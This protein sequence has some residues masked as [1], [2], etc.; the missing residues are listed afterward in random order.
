MA[1][2]FD[3]IPVINFDAP[4]EEVRATI[5][6]LPEKQR[7]EAL[8]AWADAYVAKER[9]EGG[10]GQAINNGVRALAR[11]TP[12]G[13]WLDEANALTSAGINTVSGGYLGAP[14][15]EAKAY[16]NAADRAYDKANPTASTVLQVAGAVGSAPLAPA[17]QV[18]RGGSLGA[19]MINAGITGAGYGAAYGLGEGDTWSEGG[20]NAAKGATLGGVI[21]SAAPAVAR[22]VGNAA[23]YVMNIVKGV[24]QGAQGFERGA[25]NR[26]SRAMTDDGLTT[27]P[28]YEQRMTPLGREGMLLDAGENLQNQAGAIA[29]QPGAGQRTLTTRLDARHG[30]ASGRIRT[31]TDAA[32]GARVNLPETERALRTHYGQAARPHYDEFYQTPVPFTREVEDVLNRVDP[33]V[34]SSAQRL[35]R[36]DGQQSN[37][38]FANILDDGTVE[39]RRVPNA[40]EWDYIKRA[41]D[42]AARG[43]TPQSNQQRIYRNLASTIN[44]TVDGVVSPGNPGASPWA[45]ARAIAGEGI[46]LRE[47]MENGQGAFSKN[48]SA[49]QMRFDLQGLSDLE[50]A[51]YTMGARAQV[52]DV[53]RNSGTAFGPNGDNAARRLLGNEN[54]RDKLELI[55]RPG[56]AERLLN[57]LDAETVFERSRQ[58]VTGNSATSRRLQAQKEFPNAAEPVLK[59]GGDTS[60]YGRIEQGVMKVANA[61]T[62]GVLNE[63]N[64]RIAAD[65][66]DMLSRQGNGR[67]AIARALIAYGQNRQMSQQGREAIERVARQLLTGGR[68]SAIAVGTD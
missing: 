2:L 58:G 24:P 22:G 33:A 26:V 59:S 66:A 15:E 61:L 12:V 31:D 36:A 8:N 56:G 52:D 4:A 16:Q 20:E 11:G 6:K 60:L 14:Y 5:A 53:M 39:M 63:R 21:G 46:G 7:K 38:F 18:V 9:E 67:D 43:A 37:Q 44:D 62:G 28:A 30:G 3:D 10:V 47:A 1:G 68:Q 65:A 17:A 34:V 35:M 48:L 32:L 55:A 29:N 50:R 13:S 40:M 49:D 41:I 64:A 23:E 27:V 57:R 54:A 42:D 45:Q 25:V 51:G 19:Q